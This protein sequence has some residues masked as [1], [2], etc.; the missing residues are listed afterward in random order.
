MRAVAMRAHEEN[1]AGQ[2]K[3]AK[4]NRPRKDSNHWCS[5]ELPMSSTQ[6]LKTPQWMYEILAGMEKINQ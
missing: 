6:V 1:D 4:A 3:E 5:T 2:M